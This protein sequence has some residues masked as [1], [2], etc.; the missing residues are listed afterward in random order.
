[1]ATCPICY[2]NIQ[3]NK[4]QVITDCNHVFCF[5][6][7]IKTVQAD[8]GFQCPICRNDWGWDEHENSSDS[9]SEYEPDFPDSEQETDIETQDDYPTTQCANRNAF[10]NFWK[11][12]YN[13]V[14]NIYTKTCDLY[15]YYRN[16]IYQLTEYRTDTAIRITLNVFV[17]S[18]I[19]Y[20]AIAIY[21]GGCISD[22]VISIYMNAGCAENTVGTVNLS[23]V[24]DTVNNSLN[25][26]PTSNGW[27]LSVYGML[28]LIATI[29]VWFV[30]RKILKTFGNIIYNDMY[31]YRLYLGQWNI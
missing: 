7:I 19:L 30:N 11:A 2:E 27:E 9:S 21:L 28:K 22:I 15:N 10:I 18:S 5:S 3:I 16:R 31:Y 12:R 20:F 26:M 1:M 8:N 29:T 4:N 14:I 6:C 24:T 13:S 25:T 17:L 23:Q